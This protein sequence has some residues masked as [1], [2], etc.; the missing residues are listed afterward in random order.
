MDVVI[1]PS[2]I[3]KIEEM[4]AKISG[5]SS[6]ASATQGEAVEDEYQAPTF[7]RRRSVASLLSQVPKQLKALPI[8]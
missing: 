7:R 1:E 3:A 6:A 4:E 8:P 2:S 5:T